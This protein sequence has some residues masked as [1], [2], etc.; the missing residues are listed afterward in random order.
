MG[1][2]ICIVHYNT[3]HLT[4]CLVKSINK[5]VPNS[6]IY[7]FDNSDKLP[8]RYRQ[9]NLV[10]FDNTNGKIIDF[11]KWL[12][13]YPNR[14]QSNGQNNNYASAKHC[15]TIQKCIELIDENFILLDSDVLLKK[16]ITTIC[17]DSFIYVGESVFQTNCKNIK[18]HSIKRLLP[19]M[20]F[21]NVSLCKQNGIKYFDGNFMNGLHVTEHGDLYDTGG[22]FYKEVKENNL[23]CKEIKI[24][25][26]IVHYGAGSWSK[27]DKKEWLDK[28]NS[29]FKN[30]E[31]IISLT[32]HGERIKQIIPT[33]ESLIKQTIKPDKIILNIFQGESNKVSKELVNYCSK[34]KIEIYY[35]DREIGPHAKYF[36]TM[37]RFKN[38]CI[39]T[40]DDDIIYTN[41]LVSSLYHDFI[42]NDS[43][44][45]ARRVHKILYK[46]DIP[47]EYNKWKYEC[48]EDRNPGYDIFP[49]GVGGVLYPPD[50]LKIS[51]ECLNDIYKSLY[52]DDI[53][54]KYRSNSLDIMSKWVVN[55]KVLP[56]ENANRITRK[57]ALSLEN[58]LKNRNDKYIKDLNF[59]KHKTMNM[60]KNK[61]VV[62]TCISGNYDTLIEPEFVTEGYDYICFTDQPFT[63][64]TWKIRPIP[65]ELNGLTAVKKQRNIKINT[66][67]YLSDYEFSVWVDANTHLTGNINEY[68][69]KNCNK[70]G[71]VLYVGKHPQRD[72][73]YKEGEVCVKLKKDTKEN[74]DRQLNAYRKEGFP[75]HYGL[76]QTCILLRYHNEESCIKLMETWWEQLEKYSHR[77][78]LSF[79]YALWKNQNT[80]IEYVDK[81]IFNCK[82]F[83]WGIKHKKPVF[84]T[85]EKTKEFK[86]P[87]TVI[88]ESKG[89]VFRKPDNSSVNT[90]EKKRS[91][92]ADR[93]R[94]IKLTRQINRNVLGDK[95]TM[96]DY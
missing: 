60:E 89:V 33:L 6:K 68:V 64:N 2:N 81:S 76:P 17:D 51:D 4:S 67:K 43:Y 66:H 38:A 92:L 8:F 48:K 35:Y 28:Y 7:I 61:K 45:L 14:N 93:I 39:I 22:S 44:I 55:N 20:C 29:Y 96:N 31:I 82:Y 13:N 46:N 34:N 16:D 41:D 32:S 83:K 90:P 47:L 53:Y 54:L 88:K 69:D 26:Y 65:S 63:S 87:T 23:P 73:I 42:D 80:K 37:K 91:V 3:P 49:T 24:S 79:N 50:I 84:K 36:Y 78:Q 72:C 59:K 57:S 9:D 70:E 86:K 21:I 71:V 74:V 52:A 95:Y 85:E 12:L 77:D 25:D 27:T 30:D 56:R 62:Y 18:Q 75:E 19:F 5:F 10:Y 58:N 11:D 15:Y 1:I 94:Q 40:V